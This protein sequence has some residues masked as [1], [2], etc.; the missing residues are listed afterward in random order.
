MLTVEEVAPKQSRKELEEALLSMMITEPMKMRRYMQEINS[1][2]FQFERNEIFHF[3]KQLPAKDVNMVTVL[4]VAEASKKDT[5]WGGREY[6][7]D[8]TKSTPRPIKSVVESIVRQLYALQARQTVSD[9]SLRLSSNANNPTIDPYKLMEEA[10]Q[11]LV[12]QLPLQNTR[13]AKQMNKEIL[14]PDKTNEFFKF[15]IE[16][17]DDITCGFEPGEFI[18]MG[19]STSM[20]KTATAV[21]IFKHNVLDDKPTG[22]FSL[23]MKDR[24]LM[25]RIY[26]SELSILA[27]S[28][29]AGTITPDEGQQIVEFSA[30]WDKCKWF[31]D[32]KSRKL[33]RIC[34]RI[35][36]KVDEGYKR[37]VIDYLQLIESGLNKR[38]GNREQEI[39][40][41]SRTLQELCNSEDINII[42]LSQLSREHTKRT[43]KRPKL[44]DLRES[45]S[46]EQDADAVIFPFRPDYFLEDTTRQRGEVEVMEFILAKGRSI[47]TGVVEAKWYDK[48][49]KII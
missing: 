14:N 9:V 42:A 37:F 23:E 7:M 28:L 2:L 45:G 48:Y 36:A 8:I 26:S 3:I 38:N 29:R 22:F 6:L 21:H 46:I 35:R 1:D 16:Q 43:N 40:F 31:I 32:D 13:T 15:Y 11:D 18:I 20:G 30:E 24:A 39:A 25:Q 12:P 44:S 10:R 47:G 33:E 41:I 27:R 49:G 19:G 5:E 17:L 4:E 34:N